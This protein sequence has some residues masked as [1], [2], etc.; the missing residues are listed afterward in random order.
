MNE[1]VDPMRLYSLNEIN[2]PKFRSQI[3]HLYLHA[4]ATGEQAQYIDPQQAESRLDELVKRGMGL[5]A[6]V[7]DR[8]AGV[9]LGMPLQQDREFPVYE[10][11]GTAVDTSLYIAELMVHA[12]LR[13]QGIATA[14]ITEMLSRAAETH[15]DVVIRVWDEN[16]PALSLYHKLGF[17]PVA[18]ITQT[19]K[20]VSGESFEMRK[21]YLHKHLLPFPP[22]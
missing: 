15:T 5:M 14:L 9:V 13:G 1:A 4:F 11:P 20:H 21:I 22:A 6:F 7:G 17:H 10:V 18:T 19:K 3:I 16:K 8:L 12:D 2:Y